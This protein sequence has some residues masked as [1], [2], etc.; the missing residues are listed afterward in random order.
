[1]FQIQHNKTYKTQ[2][3]ETKRFAIFRENLEAIKQHNDRYEQGLTRYKQGKQTILCIV[4]SLTASYHKQNQNNIDYYLDS[5]KQHLK[6]KPA[7]IH[8]IICC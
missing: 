7:S 6:W 4:R 5:E 3:E 8:L 2:V 1:M